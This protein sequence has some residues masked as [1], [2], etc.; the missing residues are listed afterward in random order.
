M[1]IL[2]I[3]LYRR[4]KVNYAWFHVKPNFALSSECVKSPCKIRRIV[5]LQ[6]TYI[7]R[8]LFMKYML[9]LREYKKEERDQVEMATYCFS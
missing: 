9:T 7:L 4:L 6:E 5:G 8:K 3:C 2:Q 1:R